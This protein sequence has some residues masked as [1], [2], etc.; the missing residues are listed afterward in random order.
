MPQTGLVT[1]IRITPGHSGSVIISQFGFEDG[2]EVLREKSSMAMSNDHCRGKPF[3]LTSDTTH[4]TFDSYEDEDY[5]P[6]YTATYAVATLGMGAPISQWWVYQF[7][8]TMAGSLAVRRLRIES[9]L[10]FLIYARA[11]MDNDWFLFEIA[12]AAQLASAQHPAAT[13][14]VQPS[15]K[16]MWQLCLMYE[17]GQGAEAN[18]KTSKAWCAEAEVHGTVKLTGL[19]P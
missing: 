14:S 18:M 11:V 19:N 2:E 13:H 4:Q 10:L 16:A 1:H 17:L 8:P 5:D 9:G 12:D 15:K 3:T 6:L 7:R